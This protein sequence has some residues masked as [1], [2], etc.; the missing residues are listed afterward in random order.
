MN[1]DPRRVPLLFGNLGRQTYCDQPDVLAERLGQHYKLLDFG[2]APGSTHPFCHRSFTATV[3]ELT[4]TCGYASPIFGVMG[5]RSQVGSINLIRAGSVNY[6]CQK[7]KYQISEACPL[8]FSPSVE[9]SYVSNHY[10]GVVFDVSL[11]RLTETG[12]AMLG[13][14]ELDLDGLCAFASCRMV[15]PDGNRNKILIRHLC[16]ALSLM[17]GSDILPRTQLMYLQIDDLVYRLIAFI[18]LPAKLFS[19]ARSSIP[20]PLGRDHALE[21]L[22]EWIRENLGSSITLTMLEQRSGYSRRSLQKAFQA[23]FGCGPIQWVRRQ[24]LEQARLALLSPSSMDNVSRIANRFGYNSL[25]VFSR[26]FSRTYGIS[27][28]DLLHQGRRRQD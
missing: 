3:G 23:R 15:A 11:T 27:A 14:P 21:D 1:V 13:Q 19:K 4:V 8:F 6:Y 28:S 20:Q 10:S 17:D 5:E 16:A 12:A 22:I 26:D 25:S 18:L 24:R 9:Y 2:V 7:E